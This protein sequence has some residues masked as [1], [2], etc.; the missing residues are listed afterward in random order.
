MGR[1]DA[2]VFTESL[3]ESCARTRRGWTT[4]LSFA[5]QTAVVAA[6]VLLP[7]FYTQALPAIIDLGRLIGPPPGK[8]P[9]AASTERRATRNSDSELVGDTVRE[10][11]RI[12]QGV[13]EVHDQGAPEPV[14][15]NG[16]VIPGGTGSREAGTQ[17]MA[18]FA[19]PPRP[20]APPPP[21]PTRRVAVSC[22]VLQG[23]LLHQVRPVYPMPAIIAHVQGAVVLSAVI[24]RAGTI[25][26][27]HVVSGHPLLV[28]A[29]VEAVR[30]WR[31][32]PYLLN[33]EPVEVDTQITVNFT[34]GGG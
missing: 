3:L 1:S 18:L 33:G 22:G 32:R 14:P 12:R 15:D 11:I 30:Q 19:V 16:L 9:R 28:R 31:Y 4:F 17:I 2:A 21:V 25:E 8:V 27:L 29:A 10:P 13:A 24:S 6:L 20:A 7:L 23:F 34:L 26:N 5:A